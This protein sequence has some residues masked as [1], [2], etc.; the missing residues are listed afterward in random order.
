MRGYTIDA[1]MS[2]VNSHWL[3]CIILGGEMEGGGAAV[4]SGCDRVDDQQGETTWFIGKRQKIPY[5]KGEGERGRSSHHL[6]SIMP[7]AGKETGNIEDPQRVAKIWLRSGGENVVCTG[8]PGYIEQHSLLGADSAKWVGRRKS[9]VREDGRARDVLFKLLYAKGGSLIDMK[10]LQK[11]IIRGSQGIT[12]S[13]PTP[14]GSQIPRGNS[15]SRKRTKAEPSPNKKNDGLDREGRNITWGD[16]PN[17]GLDTFTVSLESGGFDRKAVPSSL[18]SSS[19]RTSSRKKTKNP[20]LGSSYR[21]SSYQYGSLNSTQVDDPLKA[22]MR[23]T[24]EAN[25]AM[26]TSSAINRAMRKQLGKEEEAAGRSHLNAKTSGHKLARSLP[27]SRGTK[28][29]LDPPLNTGETDPAAVVQAA[30][31]LQIRTAGAKTSRVRFSVDHSG[32]T[33]NCAKRLERWQRFLQQTKRLTTRFEYFC[34]LAD[35]KLSEAQK[36]AKQA[37]L[38]P[39][40]AGRAAANLYKIFRRQ[41]KSLS[42]ALCVHA[43]GLQLPGYQFD[44]LA[45]SQVLS[46]EIAK[47]EEAAKRNRRK[48]Y[49]Y[50]TKALSVSYD[51]F[52]VAYQ[53][54]YD[55]WGDVQY[56]LSTAKNLRLFGAWQKQKQAMVKIEEMPVLI[57]DLRKR[58]SQL[59]RSLGEGLAHDENEPSH[60]MKTLRSTA[61]P[62]SEVGTRLQ[63]FELT[64]L[65]SNHG[66]RVLYLAKYDVP[67]A[68]KQQPHLKLLAN[69]HFSM[70]ITSKAVY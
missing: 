13:S 27:H 1:C 55:I 66:A 15:H 45:E 43:P 22:T 50:L 23:H 63:M 19:S 10:L 51:G 11:D 32:H 37:F 4:N 2:A 60:K 68:C 21:E 28:N 14:E 58:I 56:L 34:K 35:R 53:S 52:K 36:E 33:E 38:T 70:S 47:M 62:T 24:I 7:M 67:D 8:M 18:L 40:A 61:V 54:S 39:F 31:S 41:E 59:M 20:V 48:T 46:S 5:D 42:D 17:T 44:F 30:T 49:A 26:M 9:G 65:R 25:Q 64:M 57:E 69:A 29:D 12:S 16:L 3:L 6:H